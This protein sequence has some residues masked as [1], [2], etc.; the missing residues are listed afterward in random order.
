M[1][2]QL[3]ASAVGSAA[4]WGRQSKERTI[5]TTC[6]QLACSLSRDSDD[7]KQDSVEEAPTAIAKVSKGL[8]GIKTSTKESR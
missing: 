4:A 7:E 2:M 8:F 5:L 6:I 1:G 3:V